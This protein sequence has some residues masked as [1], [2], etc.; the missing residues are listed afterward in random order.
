MLDQSTNM[1]SPCFPR[2]R[3]GFPF[4]AL[5]ALT[6]AAGVQADD[7]KPNV[8]FLISDDLRPELGCY[9]NDVI[10]TPNIDRLAARGMV[11]QR[12]YCQQAVCSPS[13]TSVMTGARPDTTKVWDLKTH[14]RKAMPGCCHVAAVFSPERLHDQRLRQDLSRRTR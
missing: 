11:F 8:L 7:T 1:P 5:I 10:K 12:A 3:V 14:F 6:F 13:R 9:G 2:S 4:V